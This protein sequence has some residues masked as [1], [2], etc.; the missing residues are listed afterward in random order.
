MYTHFLFANVID[1]KSKRLEG[2]GS[3]S[4]HLAS[5]AL[6]ESHYSVPTR[7]VGTRYAGTVL[8]LPPPRFRL[9]ALASSLPRSAWERICLTS[10]PRLRVRV[11]T[12]SPRGAWGPGTPAQSPHSH[13]PRGSEEA[14][15]A[16]SRIFQLSLWRCLLNS[17]QVQDCNPRKRR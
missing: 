7:S 17:F 3:V 6:R 14:T 9:L 15:V 12:L 2:K 4:L 1:N 13:A 10:L 5:T 16:N 11:T 8:S